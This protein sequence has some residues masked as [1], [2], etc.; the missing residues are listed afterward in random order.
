M[1]RRNRALLSGLLTLLLIA[2][3]ADGG[4]PR[5]RYSVG[6]GSYGYGSWYGC[7]YRC[8]PPVVVVPGPGIDIDPGPGL[9]ATPLPE[10]GAD[11]GDAGFDVW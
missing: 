9:E 7:G 4:S 3:C 8:N 6:V 5:V 1:K 10:M 11:F 2:A